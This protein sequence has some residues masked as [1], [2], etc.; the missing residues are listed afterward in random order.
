MKRLAY[1]ALIALILAGCSSERQAMRRAKRAARLIEKAE[2]IDPTISGL[3]TIEHNIKM[4]SPQVDARISQQLAIPLVNEKPQILPGQTPVYITLHDTVPRFTFPV[5]F[6]D[7]TLL[8]R[9]NIEGKSLV[10]DYTVKPLPVDTVFKTQ[11]KTLQK[12]KYLPLPLP[13]YKEFL[14]YTGGLAL[15]ILAIIITI[16]IIERNLSR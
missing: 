12:T 16:R 9:I 6:E 10:L 13:W 2:R 8:A 1:I 5:D 7:D 4:R 3:K 15:I 14:I 11:Y